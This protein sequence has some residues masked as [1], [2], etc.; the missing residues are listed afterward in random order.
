MPELP[1]VE[2]FRRYLGA[3][4]L[5][6]RIERIQVDEPTVLE[7]ISPQTLGRRL[8]HRRFESTSRRGK[9]LFAA[10]DAGGALVLHFGMTGH[11]E[12]RRRAEPRPDY[13]VL[14]ILFEDDSALF[15][16]APRKLGTSPSP[17]PS[18]PLSSGMGW[19]PTP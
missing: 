16:V 15:Y 8:D 10:L 4:A 11:L 12:Y 13:T 2:T 19:A 7:A 5:H 17:S 9:Y 1:D 6:R 3:T 14:S 18:R